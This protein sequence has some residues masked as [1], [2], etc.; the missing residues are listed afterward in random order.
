M[1]TEKG[2]LGAVENKLPLPPSHSLF[3]PMLVILSWY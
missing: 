1:F 2:L 3:A